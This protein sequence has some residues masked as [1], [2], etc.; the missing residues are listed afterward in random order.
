MIISG[1]ESRLP[2]ITF[3][4]TYAIVDAGQVQLGEPLSLA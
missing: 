3:F 1:L 2:L 4:E